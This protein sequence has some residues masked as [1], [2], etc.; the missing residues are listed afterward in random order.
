LKLKDALRGP[1]EIYKAS[2]SKHLK[3]IS[4]KTNVPLSEMIF[5]DN[6]YG[7]CQTVAGVGVTV[8]YTPEGMTNE[9]FQEAL[10]KYP[11]PGK[12]L[13]PAGKRGYW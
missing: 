8:M 7:N 6:E 9:L 13:G 12:V 3:A 5:F 1:L 10:R 4:K 11:S 2:K